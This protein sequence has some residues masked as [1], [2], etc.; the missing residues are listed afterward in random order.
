MQNYVLKKAPGNHQR[1]NL[2]SLKP[3]LDSKYFRQLELPFTFGLVCPLQRHLCS[4]FVKMCYFLSE[5]AK[6]KD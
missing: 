1:E 4:N 3:L 2:K 5:L 6:N